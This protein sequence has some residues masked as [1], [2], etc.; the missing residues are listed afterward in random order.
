[1]WHV[2]GT[3]RGFDRSEAYEVGRL[4]LPT[5][6]VP[7]GWGFLSVFFSAWTVLALGESSVN[8]PGC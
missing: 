5:S 4:T 8:I 6:Y 3:D 2:T 7:S 1:M